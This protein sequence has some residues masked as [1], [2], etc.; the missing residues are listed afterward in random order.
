ME[1]NQESD[2][3]REYTLTPDAQLDMELVLEEG[4]RLKTDQVPYSAPLTSFVVAQ[5]EEDG[6]AILWASEEPVTL[7]G[8]TS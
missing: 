1:L 4:D 2:A 7:D 8:W 6:T 3:R 5:V